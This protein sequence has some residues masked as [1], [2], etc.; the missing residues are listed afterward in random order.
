M[1]F[2]VFLSPYLYV[3]SLFLWV[4]KGSPTISFTALSF[5][6]LIL[7]TIISN[8]IFYS[9]LKKYSHLE[10]NVLL[11]GI[12]FTFCFLMF[13]TFGLFPL[14][15]WLL[16]YVQCLWI[17]LFASLFYSYTALIKNDQN[18]FNKI[19]LFFTALT[20]I[21]FIFTLIISFEFMKP[22]L[23]ESFLL[24]LLGLYWSFSVIFY[25]LG[26]K[27]WFSLRQLAWVMFFMSLSSFCFTILRIT[28]ILW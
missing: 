14:L 26:R 10:I 4:N 17:I 2:F 23:T 25:I 15:S 28:A 6:S 1:E 13:S 9:I 7:L 11:Y 16:P 18:G 8:F 20:L 3:I 19:T 27:V 22:H 24:L 12:G 21:L 5:L